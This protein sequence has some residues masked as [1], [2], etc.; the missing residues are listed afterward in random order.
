M[1]FPLYTLDQIGYEVALFLYALVGVGFGF[2]LER[3]GFG[4]APNLAAQFYGT[5]LRVLKVMFTAIV[6]A[7]VGIVLLSSA[8]VLDLQAIQVPHTYLWP[9]LAGGLL[10]GIGFILS[11]YCPGTSVVAMAS[12][13][14]DGLVTV[15]GVAIGSLVYGLVYPAISSFA[16]SGDL[17][18]LR[19]TDLLGLPDAVL[20]A[21]VLGMATGAFLLGEAAE[22]FFSRRRDL[23]V[24]GGSFRARNA[25]LSS[26]GAATAMALVLSLAGVGDRSPGTDPVPLT[27]TADE[28]AATLVEDPRS[29][30]VLDLRDPASCEKARIPGALCRRPDDADLRMVRDLPPFRT[31]VLYGDGDA[32]TIPK[33]ALAYRG[34]LAVLAGGYQAF[35]GRYLT[36]P[37]E[38]LARTDPASYRRL[39]AIH[40]ILTGT[41]AA[42]P[43][44]PPSPTRMA[45]A[46]KKKGGGC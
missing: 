13:K 5:D 9:Q 11:G 2:A 31:L 39:S 28:L 44:P 41:A 35:A 3:A 20:A 34:R 4:Y 7:C 46:V 42:P 21:A 33:N 27:L 17:G 32:E 19:W 29:L 12:G 40:S 15:V 45:P 25:I 22:R 23:P 24:P 18:V 26:L 8:G 36:P 1:T 10:L 16:E 43:P 14:W 38:S 37:D 30:W 6:T